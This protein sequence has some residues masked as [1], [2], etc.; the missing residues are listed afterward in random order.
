MVND[1]GLIFERG[2]WWSVRGKTFRGNW[3]PGVIVEFYLKVLLDFIKQGLLS[4]WPSRFT[5]Q[6]FIQDFPK[7]SGK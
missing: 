6:C 4:A 5:S 1:M 3:Q 2:Q 7:M